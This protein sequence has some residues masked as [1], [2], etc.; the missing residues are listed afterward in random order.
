[1]FLSFWEN[2]KNLHFFPPCKFPGA[3]DDV[4]NH[5]NGHKTTLSFRIFFSIKHWL[6]NSRACICVWMYVHV[7]VHP[8][9]R[10]RTLPSPLPI[11]LPILH[12]QPPPLPP[13]PPHSSLS[14]R[15]TSAGPTEPNAK[16]WRGRG[17]CL[18]IERACGA[19]NEEKGAGP[20][21]MCGCY[22]FCTSWLQYF[23]YLLLP[24]C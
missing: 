13:P 21:L 10:P 16:R 11:S 6:A 3:R 24:L 18:N 2:V 23:L 15:H 9:K 7:Y 22:L 17:Y 8:H 19:K 14:W 20:G 5:I 4:Q 1:M 12:T